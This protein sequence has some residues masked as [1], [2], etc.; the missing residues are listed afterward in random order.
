M[1]GGRTGKSR[2]PIFELSG[3]EQQSR[4]SQALVNDPELILA[5]E[6]PVS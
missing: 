6:L 3:G 2:P 1:F 5:D 4:Y